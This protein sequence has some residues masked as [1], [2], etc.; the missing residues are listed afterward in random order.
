[1]CHVPVPS[2]VPR[3]RVVA[4][5][6]VPF[7]C[8]RAD[9]TP[10]AQ[11]LAAT[12]DLV[13][14]TA[15]LPLNAKGW[16]V[17]DVSAE[18]LRAWQRASGEAAPPPLLKALRIILL[19]PDPRPSPLRACAW[20]APAPELAMVLQD[21]LWVGDRPAPVLGAL[22]DR[23]MASDVGGARR[24]ALA[25][26]LT[27]RQP[28]PEAGSPGPPPPPELI[29]RR[30]TVALE[31]LRAAWQAGDRRVAML[32]RVQHT[33]DLLQRLLADGMQVVGSQWMTVWQVVVAHPGNVHQP[34]KL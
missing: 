30:N 7:V 12:H 22:L 9:P 26:I 19:G 8:L 18:R 33:P 34:P 3:P 23:L 21:W 29:A 24:L 14:Q 25:Q 17:A 31:A 15:A 13:P 4:P 10:E 1:M 20:L 5:P 2:A 27:S 6:P 32:Y 11:Q 16:Y 28:A